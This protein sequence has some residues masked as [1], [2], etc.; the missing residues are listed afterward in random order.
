MLKAQGSRLR[1]FTWHL[2]I[3]PLPLD[4]NS[5]FYLFNL[6]TKVHISSKMLDFYF[7]SNFYFAFFIQSPVRTVA[8]FLYHGTQNNNKRS[9][10]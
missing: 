10:E 8:F 3:G 7:I 1:P 6:F 2:V 4:R 5:Q 9:D